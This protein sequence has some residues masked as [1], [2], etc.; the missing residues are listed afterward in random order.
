MPC[1]ASNKDPIQQG[2]ATPAIAA[3]SS[4]VVSA[5]FTRSTPGSYYAHVYVDNY[6]VL[7]HSNTANHGYLPSFPTRRSSDLLPDL[8]PASVVPSSTSVVMSGS[9]TITVTVQNQ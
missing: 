5:T 1:S 6:S 7:S 8:V 9:E 3:G 4:A 2:V